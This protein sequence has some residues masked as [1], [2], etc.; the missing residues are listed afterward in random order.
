MQR[1]GQK[2]SES[3]RSS[4]SRDF[5][6]LSHLSFPTFSKLW[7]HLRLWRVLPSRPKSHISV[8]ALAAHAIPFQDRHK[9]NADTKEDASVVEYA[10]ER[11]ILETSVLELHYY[12]DVV[13][14]VPPQHVNTDGL[15]HDSISG[16]LPPEWGIELVMHGGFVRY[17]PWADRKRYELR[18]SHTNLLKPSPR[19]ELQHTFF[20]PNYTDYD[21]HKPSK[22]GEFRVWTSL[23]IFMELRDGVTL[24]VPFREASKVGGFCSQGW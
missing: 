7:R 22:P 23:Q 10:E 6:H 24:Q 3:I 21:P 8:H 1:E 16:N 17:G 13:G 4:D 12:A 14:V 15:H 20:P 18:Q 2:C 5:H 9:Q 11:K 19:V